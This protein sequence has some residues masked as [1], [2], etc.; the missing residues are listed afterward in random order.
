ME[1]YSDINL[2]SMVVLQHGKW[3]Y[4]LFFSQTGSELQLSALLFLGIFG[5]GRNFMIY[6]LTCFT[7]CVTSL[8]LYSCI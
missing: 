1:H 6:K 5:T 7:E 2:D 3:K 4:L 8:V